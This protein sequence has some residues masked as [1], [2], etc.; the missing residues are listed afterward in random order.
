[1]QDFYKNDAS[2]TQQ[3]DD[4]FYSFIWS[5]IV[6]QPGVRVGKLPE[7]FQAD[8][9]V[10]PDDAQARKKTGLTGKQAEPPVELVVIPDAAIRPL[11]DL[12]VEHGE[13]LRIAVDRDRVS[14][15]LIGS[16]IRVRIC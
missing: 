5:L 4:A 16:H 1:M 7:D 14:M 8:V 15:A 3:L 9:Y 10:A 11:G 12:I 13:Q 2:Q 6:Q